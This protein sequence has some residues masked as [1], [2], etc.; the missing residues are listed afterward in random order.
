MQ[1][2]QGSGQG[3]RSFMVPHLAEVGLR[4]I[5]DRFEAERVGVLHCRLGL[6]LPRRAMG[7]RARWALH[8]AFARDPRSRL[9]V[10]APD[11]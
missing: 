8:K 2:S 1:Q 7:G 4:N 3:P 5:A 9:F 10:N 11:N 6:C